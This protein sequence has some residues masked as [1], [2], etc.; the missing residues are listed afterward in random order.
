MGFFA[1]IGKA[2]KNGILIKGGNYLE[3]L[4]RLDTVIFDKTGT[5]TRGV[6]K[7]VKIQTAG[8]F[9]R[10][11]L[12]E[13]AANAECFFFFFIAL[14]IMNEFA[15][16]GKEIQKENL[17][18]YTEYA[19]LGISVKLNGSIIL[20]G[21]Q[22]LMKKN[23]ISFDEP[24]ESG[25]KVFIA[26]NGQFAGCIIIND[27][28]KEDSRAAIAAL[29]EKGIKKT[30][31]L[32]GDNPAA[33]KLIADE[34]RLDEAYGGLLPHEKVQITEKIKGQLKNGKFAFVG[35]G[36][37]DAPSL[38]IADIGIAMG[39]LGSDAAI[40][41]ADVVLMSDEPT[42]LAKAIDISRFTGK[43]VRQNIV[44]TL[45]VK[46]VFLALGAAGIAT[47]WEAVFADAGVSLLAVLNAMRIMRAR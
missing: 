36:I 3:A 1:G 44:F 14:S 46:V 42:K 2:A 45:C 32:S 29:K 9:A 47:M 21:N 38:A 8:V 13:L 17:S 35:D 23:N 43:I 31:M 39:A 22:N 25:T 15:S 33:V 40:E 7:V 34:L 16:S 27:E 30:V 37:N 4:S 24:Q 5:L 28:I 11:D 6:F 41:A 18:E 19:G 12:L 20:A 26:F 10:D